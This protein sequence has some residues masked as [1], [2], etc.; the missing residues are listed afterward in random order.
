[1]TLQNRVLPTGEIVADPGRGTL[2]GNRGI[3]HG[4]DRRLGPRRWAHPH[5]IACALDWK[6]VRRRPM[7]PGTWTELFFLDEAVALAAGHRPCALCRRAAFRAF[8]T[9]WAAGTGLPAAAPAIDRALH[10]A[11]V[12]RDRRQLRHDARAETLPDGAMVLWQGAAHL[13]AGGALRRFSM[14]GYGGPLPLPGAAAVTVLTP[15]PTIAALAA[16]YRPLL[17]PTAGP[18]Q[19]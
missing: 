14:Q 18:A 15:A 19:P 17:H 1:M 2:T 6:G 16:G 9:A 11:R 10:A 3:L 5:W 13:V 4:A 12:T 8:Q 7:T